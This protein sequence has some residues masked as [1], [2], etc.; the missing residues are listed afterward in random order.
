MVFAASSGA[1]RRT[2]SAVSAETERPPVY[3]DKYVATRG[4]SCWTA[5]SVGSTYPGR[6]WPVLLDCKTEV[7][8]GFCNSQI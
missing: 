5:P 2:S 8:L 6:I 3:I 4:L 1:P 7:W